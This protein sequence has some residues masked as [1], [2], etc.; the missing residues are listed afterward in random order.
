[1]LG[2]SQERLSFLRRFSLMEMFLLLQVSLDPAGAGWILATEYRVW[3]VP[4]RK[5]LSVQY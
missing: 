3:K 1:M 2:S 5:T 4:P